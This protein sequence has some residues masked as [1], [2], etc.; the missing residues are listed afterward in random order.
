[1]VPT[2]AR[3]QA[4]ACGSYPAQYKYLTARESASD[5]SPNRVHVDGVPDGAAEQE[6]EYQGRRSDI[7]HL[8][9]CHA[10]LGVTGGLVGDFVRDY[11]CQLCLVISGKNQ[12]GVY[13]DQPTSQRNSVN[14]VPG[15]D[16]ERKLNWYVQIGCQLLSDAIHIISDSRECGRPPN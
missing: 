11:C 6:S 10:L 2:L 7:R 14:F 5:S 1:M 12:A 15:D 3:N 16:F 4:R 9:S 8:P 13:K